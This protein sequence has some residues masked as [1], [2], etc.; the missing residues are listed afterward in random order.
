MMIVF[1][2]SE[3]VAHFKL[4]ST[5]YVDCLSATVTVTVRITKKV[6]IRY[7]IKKADSGLLQLSEHQQQQYMVIST[8]KRS[9]SDYKSI[10]GFNLYIVDYPVDIIYI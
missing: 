7:K 9:Y 10:P 4:T 2:K 8:S 3:T 1:E 6:R 5:F